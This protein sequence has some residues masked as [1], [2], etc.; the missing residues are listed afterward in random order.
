MPS[1]WGIFGG[2]GTGSVNSVTGSGPITVNNTDPANPVVGETGLVES[3]TGTGAITVDNTDPANP[4]VQFSG[5]TN[6]NTDN[7]T[8]TLNQ[9]AFNLSA[10]PADVTAALMFVNGIQYTYTT[11]FTITGT[12]LTWTDAAFTMVAG[13]IVSV[14]YGV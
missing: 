7:F 13:F 14:H 12:V 5:T 9:T 11:D 10:T 6:L 4:V 2:G 3:V 1:P 8:A